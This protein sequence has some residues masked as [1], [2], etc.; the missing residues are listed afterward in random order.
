M[1]VPLEVL[2]LYRIASETSSA[3]GLSAVYLHAHKGRLRAAATDGRRLVF[4][5][6]GDAS[7]VAELPDGG[8]FIPRDVCENAVS[9][10]KYAPGGRKAEV[11]L[12]VR[13]TEETACLTIRTMMTT[14]RWEFKRSDATFPD[15]MAVIPK[16]AED[17]ST[18]IGVCAWMF[19]DLMA[20]AA[21]HAG[22]DEVQPAVLT[23]PHNPNERIVVRQWRDDGMSLTAVHMPAPIVPADTNVRE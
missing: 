4:L 19:R 11:V 13:T 5:E 21:A 14:V 8:V 12:A 17:A 18:T 20:V 16:H 7:L 3:Y 15:Y 2:E 10:A 6:W 22:D 23:V 9:Y 1:Y